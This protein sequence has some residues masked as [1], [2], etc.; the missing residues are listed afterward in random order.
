LKKTRRAGALALP[1]K[2]KPAQGAFE[3]H[4]VSALA[5]VV[6][7]SIYDAVL[8]LERPNASGHHG[9]I[10][11]RS[12]QMRDASGGRMAGIPAESRDS[13]FG[14]CNFADIGTVEF[15]R[16]DVAQDSRHYKSLNGQLIE[17]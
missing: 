15:G 3:A 7:S 2:V 16:F 5:T 10:T 17:R 1:S 11:R 13:S 14:T 6:N 8:L 4:H 12:V 9:Q